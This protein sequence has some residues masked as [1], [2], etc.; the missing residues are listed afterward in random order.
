[1]RQIDGRSPGGIGRPHEEHILRAL[2]ANQFEVQ[3]APGGMP[4]KLDDFQLIVINNW[5]MESIPAPA[6]AALEDY[7]QKGGGLVWIAGEHNTYVDKKGAPEDPLERTLPAKL[8]PPRSPEGTAV[9]LI[10]DKSSSMEGRKIEL[11]RLAA[12]GV[13]ENLRPIDMVGV[14]IFD[15]SFQWAVPIRKAEDRASIKRF[16]SGITPDGGT[17]IAPALTEAYQRILP[18]TAVYKHIVLLTD[19]ENN[20]GKS[21]IIRAIEMLF[22]EY[23]PKFKKL[24]DH[25]HYNRDTNNQIIINT[26][27]IS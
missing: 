17:Q 8:A 12:I 6:K 15:N 23:H 19:G 9:V 2:Q 13:V 26:V 14:L 3:Q 20:S 21:N 4:P 7:V 24:E 1:M 5:D 22:G 10:I 11:A 25:D 18:Q 16:I 27:S